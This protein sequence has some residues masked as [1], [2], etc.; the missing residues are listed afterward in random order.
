MFRQ[1]L[2]AGKIQFARGYASVARTKAPLTLFGIDGKYATALFQA[3]AS[4]NALTTV[5]GDLLKLDEQLSKDAKLGEIFSSPLLNKAAKEKLIDSLGKKSE[6][7]TNFFKTLLENNRMAETRGVIAAYK[8]LMEAHRGIVSVVVTSANALNSKDLKQVKDNLTKGG[9]IKDFKEVNVVNKINP[10]ILGGMVVEFGDYTID[11]SVASRLAKIEKLLTDSISF[12]KTLTDLIQGLRANKRNETEYIQQSLS[13]IQ[14]E[15]Q[16]SDMS[17]KSVAIDKL[18]YLHMLGYDMN[19]ASFNVVEVMASPRFGEKRT[20]YLAAGQSFHQETDVLMLTT[21]LIRK[22]LASAKALE[23]SVALDGL[24]QVATRDLAQ[25]LLGDTLAV[26]GHPRPY[27]RKQALVCACR[28]VTRYPEGLH[29][30]VPLLKERLDDPDPAVVASAVS[31]VC[32]LAHANPHHY[33]SLVSK[34]YRLL[35]SSKNNW[36]LIK[37]V[38]LFAWLTPIEPRLAKKLHGPLSQL[39]STTAARSLLYECIH[40]AVVGGII[41]VQLPVSDSTGREVDF[42]ELCTQ[43]LELFYESPDHNLRYVGLVMLAQLQAHRPE[44]VAAHYHT[45]LRCLDDPD[46]SIRMRV[47]EVISGMP[48]CKT[49][50]PTV[51]HLMPQLVLSNT[52]ALQPDR[53][54]TTTADVDLDELQSLPLTDA[55]GTSLVS[56]SNAT[57]NPKYQLAAAEAIPRSPSL[58]P[59][60]MDIASDEDMP[61]ISK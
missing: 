46:V 16:Q 26:V 13:E 50:V 4:K 28:L 36:M 54:A 57:G 23:V 10:S 1:T 58:P 34:L 60:P 11:M 42:A 61:D 17:Q 56:I 55:A 39:V 37:I 5:E 3:A 38:K 45:V 25:D 43:K 24:A 8:S 22:D 7:T 51:K 44:L 52:V 48:T 53:I 40:M 2:R 47:I 18:G 20:G 31:V 12:E 14:R 33:L 32:E 59:A 27:I 19:W 41:D 49:L 6:I 30:F 15:V 29:E 9:L 21:N 35:T